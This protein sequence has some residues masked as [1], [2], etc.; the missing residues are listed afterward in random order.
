MNYIRKALEKDIPRI[1]ELLVQV[2]MVHHEGRPDIFKGPSTKYTQQELKE[3]IKNDKTPVFVCVDEKDV[4]L[5]HAF[6][7]HKQVTS[8]N[9][10][11]DIKTLYIDDL[12][13]D[14]M[15]RGMGIGSLLM[16]TIEEYAKTSGFYNVTLN[17]Y[18]CNKYAL[19][20]YASKGFTTRKVE[21]E[22]VL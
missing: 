17:V 16:D 15:F 8:S 10:L 21:M 12:C 18:T 1:L 11:T 4:V 6:C 19:K 5:A 7:V 9:I 14:E 3:I 13:V 2:N 20:F 22:K